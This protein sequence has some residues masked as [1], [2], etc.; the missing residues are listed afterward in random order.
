MNTVS[1]SNIELETCAGQLA[2]TFANILNACGYSGETILRLT[3]LATDQIMEE[4]SP[5][6]MTSSVGVHL[7]CTDL[8]FMWRHDPLFVDQRGEPRRLKA[9]G[10]DDSFDALVAAAAPGYDSNTIRAYLADLGAVRCWPD[11]SSDLATESV[12][13]CSGT[14]GGQVASEVVLQHLQGFL[15]SFEYNLCTKTSNEAGRFERAC[16]STIPIKLVP[17][18]EKLVH[19]RGQDFIDSMDEWLVRHRAEGPSCDGSVM[20]GTGAYLFV[21]EESGEGGV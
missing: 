18:F 12:L 21:R 20:V 3:R 2:Q 7:A 14:N 16:Y 10:T 11:G 19:D 4:K 6:S 1:S 17:V 8:V 15:G 9:T 13:V 5:R